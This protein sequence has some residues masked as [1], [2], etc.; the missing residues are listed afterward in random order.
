[1]INKFSEAVEQ[2]A[3]ASREN[4]KA[5]QEFSK[6]YVKCAEEKSKAMKYLGASMALQHVDPEER[7]SLARNLIAQCLPS[8]SQ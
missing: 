5:M 6:N 2:L 3:Q 4:A 8:D 1:M 7:A